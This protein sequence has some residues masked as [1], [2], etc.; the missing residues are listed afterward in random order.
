MIIGGYITKPWYKKNT[1]Y[2][3]N[4]FTFYVKD[5]KII[6]I[7]NKDKFYVYGQASSKKYFSFQPGFSIQL[8]RDS[9]KDYTMIHDQKCEMPEDKHFTLWKDGDGLCHFCI[10]GGKNNEFKA[11]ELEVFG[12]V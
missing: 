11:V 10:A 9:A 6:F 1:N 4:V 12:I 3:K 8:D 5:K 7:K 2:T